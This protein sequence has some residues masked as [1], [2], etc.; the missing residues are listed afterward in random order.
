MALQYD[1]YLKA[2]YCLAGEGAKSTHLVLTLESEPI[3]MIAVL[4]A[5]MDALKWE[6]ITLLTVADC[7]DLQP[8]EYVGSYG[9][10][11]DTWT[12]NGRWR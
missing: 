9:K 2:F 11:D 12:C 10:R 5:P 6:N 7:L 8:Y 1:H 3:T 4:A